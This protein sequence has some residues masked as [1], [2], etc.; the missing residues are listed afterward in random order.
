MLAAEFV[1]YE[2]LHPDNVPVEVD[3]ATAALEG[4]SATETRDSTS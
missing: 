1:S 3:D 4:T 2:H